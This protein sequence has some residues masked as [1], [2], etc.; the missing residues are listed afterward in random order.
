MSHCVAI[1]TKWDEVLDWVNSMSAP[2]VRK[3]LSVV[4]YV[5]VAF[6]DG[7]VCLFKIEFAGS[8][9]ISIMLDA[10]LSRLGVPLN[11]LDPNRDFVALRVLMALN[12]R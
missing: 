3:L 11:P 9:P 5:D 8:A 10:L 4:V 7:S 6:A 12:C 1:G 2:C